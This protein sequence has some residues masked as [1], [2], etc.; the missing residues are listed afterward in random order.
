M[1]KALDA[2]RANVSV[3]FRP[4]LARRGQQYDAVVQERLVGLGHGGG[5]AS[6]AMVA[7]IPSPRRHWYP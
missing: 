3:R 2:V 5:H 7:V 4:G 1:V 6:S